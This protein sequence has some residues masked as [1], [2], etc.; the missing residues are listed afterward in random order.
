M[1]VFETSAPFTQT[2]YDSATDVAH[3][4]PGWKACTLKR[5]HTVFHIYCRF[6]ELVREAGAGWSR[7]EQAR[8]GWLSYFGTVQCKNTDISF[9]FFLQ[10]MK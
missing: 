7:L 4:V 10:Q 3:R 6:S 9:G 1:P 2:V 5:V 8:A